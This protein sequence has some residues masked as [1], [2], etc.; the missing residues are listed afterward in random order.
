MIQRMERAGHVERRSDPEDRRVSRVYLTESG[1]AVF[2]QLRKV[3]VKVEVKTFAGFSADER[4]MLECLLQ[5]VRENLL[6]VV[7]ADGPCT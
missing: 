2:A 5:H 6:T 3:F 1:R 7:P 4:E